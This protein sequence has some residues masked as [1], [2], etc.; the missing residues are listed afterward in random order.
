MTIYT[1]PAKALRYIRKNVLHLTLEK[2]ESF[3]AVSAATVRRLELGCNVKE[4]YNHKIRDFYARYGTALV[5]YK[6]SEA[7]GEENA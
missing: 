5:A 6:N 1:V 3:T 4:N 7:G 2:V